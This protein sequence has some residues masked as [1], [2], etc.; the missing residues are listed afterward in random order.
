MKYLLALLISTFTSYASSVSLADLSFSF[1]PA[2]TNSLTIAILSHPSDGSDPIRDISTDYMNNLS[3][4]LGFTPKYT[5]FSDWRALTKAIEDKKVDVAV[6]AFLHK[7]SELIYSQPLLEI[8]T[9]AWYGNKNLLQWGAES[10]RWGCQEG[11]QYCEQLHAKGYPNILEATRYNDLLDYMSEGRIDAVLDSYIT[12]LASVK[13]ASSNSSSIDLP[14][15]GK[16]QTIRV[17]SNQDFKALI[18]KIDEVLSREEIGER[19]LS[20]HPYY[21]LDMAALSYAKTGHHAIRYS[22]WNDAYP[23]FYRDSNGQSGGYL[24]DL[25]KLTETRT[26]FSFEYVPSTD[27]QSPVDMLKYG[28]IDILPMVVKG[29]NN[30][31]WMYI[32]DTVT[33]VTYHRIML[34][35]VMTRNDAGVGVLFSDSATYQYVKDHI[36]GRDAII[37]TSVV[38]MIKD[39]ESGRLS[40]A[41]LRHDILEYLHSQ[42]GDDRFQVLSGEDKV[43]ELAMAVRGDNKAMKNILGGIMSSVSAQDIQRLENSYSPFNIIYGYD[44]SMVTI[45]IFIASA[46]VMLLGSIAF[47]WNKNLQLKV[48]LNKREAFRSN[49]K[50]ALLQHVINALPNQIFIHD[51]SFQRLLSNCK[52]AKEGRCANCVMESITAPG[53][54]IVEN[55]N[56]FEQVLDGVEVERNDIDVTHCHAGIKTVNYY[57]TQLISANEKFI[58]TVVDDVSAQKEQE[59]HLRQAKNTAQEAVASR[60]RFLASMSHELRTPIAGMVGLLEML[61]LREKDEDARL[62]LNNVMASAHHL[63]LLVNDILDFSKLEAH[64]L[65]LDLVECFMLKEVGEQLRVHCTAARE[66]SLDFQIH[67]QPCSVKSVLIDSLRVSQIINNLLS[68]AIKFTQKGFVRVDIAMTNSHVVMKFCDTGEGMTPEFLKTV[69]NPFV[70]ADSTI[71]RRY[72]GTGLGLAIVHDLVEA[73]NGDISIQSEMGR[74]T[75]ISVALPIRVLST[76][77]EPF[78]HAHINYHGN[79]RLIEQWLAIWGAV[80]ESDEGS[81]CIDIYDNTP[82]GM[83]DEEANKTIVLRNDMSG[84]SLR[85]GDVI[86]LSTTPFFADLLFDILQNAFEGKT[87]SNVV[88]E[89][90]SGHLLVAEDNPINQLVIS[91]QLASLGLDVEVVSNGQEAYNRLVSAPNHF[92]LLLTDCHMPVMD[93]Y[94]LASLVR[95]ELP[96]FSNK[97]IIGCTAEDSRVAN[98]RALLSGFDSVLYKPYGLNRLYQILAQFLPKQSD[99][100]SLWWH[101]YN[102]EDAKMMVGVFISSMNDDLASILKK[103][104]DRKAVHD[105][106]HRIK[107]GAGSVGEHQIQELAAILELQTNDNNMRYEDEFEQLVDVLRKSIETATTWLN[108]A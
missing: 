16:S 9:A 83:K 85:S 53:H 68:N 64:Q 43:I 61:K 74:G 25:L 21:K 7:D 35:G 40:S 108:H 84:F 95:D 82:N 94:E 77:D 87:E 45:G 62:I 42:H 96:E 50:L 12:L 90:L 44:K 89:L 71:A 20:N 57:R 34:P 14:L 39:L 47:L 19:N 1:T 24:N 31:S 5:L 60:E 104:H 99:D 41:Y 67:W 15:W 106:A 2:N 102:Q 28:D 70:Q 69:F 78:A 97:A 11:T 59:H 33:S 10:L 75:D 23:F 81:K 66:K 76:F 63:H 101:S 32:S 8:S 22:A 3:K 107:G 17:A 52:R 46:V 91:R 29:V 27:S 36:F 26:A 86:E 6:G 58:L 92:D 55:Q 105:L 79:N 48:S 49:E 54:C 56:E 88:P 80:G 65:E 38:S 51:S 73:M 37:Y 72:G 98:E 18:D 13:N 103:R 4:V 30:P 100:K 93:G